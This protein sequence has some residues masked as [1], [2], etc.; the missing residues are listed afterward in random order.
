MLNEYKFFTI[1]IYIYI[2][3]DRDGDKAML[4]FHT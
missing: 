1:Y 4:G 3:N 2:Y